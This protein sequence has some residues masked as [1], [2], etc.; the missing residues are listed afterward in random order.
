MMRK[1]DSAAQFHRDPLGYLDQAFSAGS[2]SG[3]LPGRQLCVAEPAAA[4]AML[5]NES[6]LYRDHSD[7]FHTR[8]GMFGPRTAQV[9]VSWGPAPV[10]PELR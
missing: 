6:G 9:S 10:V 7:F 1:Q 4:K 3:W 8:R 5:L 2:D